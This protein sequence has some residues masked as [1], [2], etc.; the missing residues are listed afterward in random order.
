MPSTIS[1]FA[2][3][4]PQ[5]GSRSAQLRCSPTTRWGR[6]MVRRNI[7]S[8]R[9][10]LKCAFT[11]CFRTRVMLLAGISAGIASSELI[12][13]F[14]RVELIQKQGISTVNGENRDFSTAIA[15]YHWAVAVKMRQLLLKKRVCFGQLPNLAGNRHTPAVREVEEDFVFRRTRRGIRRHSCT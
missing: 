9:H 3:A 11:R 1:F 14:A 7:C 13:S 2:I 12:F 15:R 8:T 5:T 6:R 10:S 4:F